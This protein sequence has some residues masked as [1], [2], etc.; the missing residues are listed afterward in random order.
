MANG[1]LF[2]IFLTMWRTSNKERAHVPIL[3]PS[4]CFIRN[5]WFKSVGKRSAV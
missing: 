4:K 1:N 5:R 3:A 2:G